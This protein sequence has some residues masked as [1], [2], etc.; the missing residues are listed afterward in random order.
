MHLG[1]GRLDPLGTAV[2]GVSGKAEGERT[3]YFRAAW[4]LGKPLEAFRVLWRTRPERSATSAQTASYRA[5]TTRFGG[6]R[7]F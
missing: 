4:S 6:A 3:P 5:G 7:S 2:P 1:H